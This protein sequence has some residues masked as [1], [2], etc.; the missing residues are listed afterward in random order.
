MKFISP[1]EGIAVNVSYGDSLLHT[2]KVRG[3]VF[4]EFNIWN[5]LDLVI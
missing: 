5:I 4:N 3:T 1:E 2:D